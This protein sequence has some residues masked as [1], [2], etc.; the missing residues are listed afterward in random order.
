MKLRISVEVKGERFSEGKLLASWLPNIRRLH[1]GGHLAHYFPGA[2]ACLFNRYIGEA[3]QEEPLRPPADLA[4]D[5]E[6]LAP[7]GRD[8]KGEARDDCIVKHSAAKGW[9]RMLLDSGLAKTDSVGH[10][11]P[12]GA[13]SVPPHAEKLGH[14]G[15]RWE[16]KL[17]RGS[18]SVATLAQPQKN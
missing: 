8:A 7:V 5:V 10:A 16:M 15:K 13:P 14:F 1:P 6:A 3:S 12:L 17:P 11:T 2:I 4:A 9:K 18:L